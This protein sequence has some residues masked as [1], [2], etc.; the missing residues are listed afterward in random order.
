MNTVALKTSRQKDVPDRNIKA[1]DNIY[2]IQ[3]ST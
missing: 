3:K 2:T 1:Q